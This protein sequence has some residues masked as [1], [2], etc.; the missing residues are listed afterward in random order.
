MHDSDFSAARDELLAL[1]DIHRKTRVVKIAD[2]PVMGRLPVQVLSLALG[3]AAIAE[4]AGSYGSKTL[5]GYSDGHDVFF[6][7]W[8]GMLIL[9]TI[10]VWVGRYHRSRS[11]GVMFEL[12]GIALII[13]ALAAYVVALWDYTKFDGT[14]I[15]AA[16]TISTI[17][18]VAGRG[19]L[20]VRRNR[21]FRKAAL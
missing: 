2:S 20:L 8:S 14:G 11:V 3:C 1:A 9:A 4:L 15:I 21:E 13:M 19:L 7:T 18:N 6:I 12:A 16:L 10:F 5:E 17:L